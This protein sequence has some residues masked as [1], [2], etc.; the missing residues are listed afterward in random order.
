MIF[1]ERYFYFINNCLS[2]IIKLEQLSTKQNIEKS[3]RSLNYDLNEA[4]DS[5]FKKLLI[6]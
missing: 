6:G 5:W 2:V 3:I 1:S 4:Y